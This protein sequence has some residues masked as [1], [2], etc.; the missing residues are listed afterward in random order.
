MLKL[1]WKAISTKKLINFTLNIKDER[2]IKK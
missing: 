1:K 2:Q